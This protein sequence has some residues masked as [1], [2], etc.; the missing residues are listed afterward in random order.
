MASS[1]RSQSWPGFL[2][3]TCPRARSP[4]WAWRTCAPTACQWV[5]AT[6]S[7]SGRMKVLSK[8][9]T[10]PGKKPVHGDTDWRPSRRS[11]SPGAIPLVPCLL[12]GLD[13]R[14]LVSTV[15]ALAAQ[16]TVGALRSLVTASRWWASGLEMLVPGVIAA[17]VDY[18]TGAGIASI[19]G[20]GV[21]RRP[22]GASEFARCFLMR[23]RP[24]S[25]T[26]AA[27]LRQRFC[28]A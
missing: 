14:F 8:L 26:F 24:E 9:G 21:E 20:P 2:K 22:S 15:A 19:V 4:S 5:S 7:A 13:H 1:Q 6:T 16:C 27:T 23:D 11:L 3:A 25:V 10:C 17:A 12:P 28:R 18:G